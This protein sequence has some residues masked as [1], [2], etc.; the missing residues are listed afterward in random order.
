[1]SATIGVDAPDLTLHF[2]DQ[3][4]L[5]RGDDELSQEGFGQP[6]RISRWQAIAQ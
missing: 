5:V 3:P 1:M 4:C 6:A 2:V